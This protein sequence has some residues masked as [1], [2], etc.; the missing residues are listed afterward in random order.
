MFQLDSTK[1]VNNS[2]GYTHT[3]TCMHMHTY[4]LSFFYYV[5]WELCFCSTLDWGCLACDRKPSDQHGQSCLLTSYIMSE[6]S[7]AV[8]VSSLYPVLSNRQILC[9]VLIWLTAHWALAQKI[10]LLS[11]FLEIS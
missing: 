7:T 2:T 10:L 3:H 6:V 5:Y 11:P 1:L 8:R 9:A 4:S